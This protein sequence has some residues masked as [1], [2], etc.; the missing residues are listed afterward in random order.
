MRILNRIIWR[1]GPYAGGKRINIFAA[2]GAGLVLFITASMLLFSPV[3]KSIAV[4]KDAWNKLETLLAENRLKI[5][6]FSKS[7]KSAIEDELEALR[8]KLPSGSSASDILDELTKRGKELNI[9][10]ISIAPQ[11][12]KMISPPQGAA[13]ALKYKIL[14]IEINMRAGYRSLG[15]Y[16]G[17]IENLKANFATV[18]EFQIGK[19]PKAPPKLNVRLVVYTYILEGQSGER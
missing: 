16:L 2:I 17:I 9:E 15:E 3:R 18:G 10:F 6:S 8:D 5:E 19:D 7:D 4:K 11:E 1:S 12:G 14:P 13:D